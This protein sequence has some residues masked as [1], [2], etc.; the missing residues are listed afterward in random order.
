[1]NCISGGASKNL[2]IQYKEVVLFIEHIMPGSLFASSYDDEWYFG[3]AN[4]ISVEK[5]DMNIKFLQPN[6]PAAQFF[7]PSLEDTCWTPIHNVITKVD[8]PLSMKYAKKVIYL[9]N[10]NE[11]ANKY[12]LLD[13][14]I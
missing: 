3:V 11:I 9:N 14:N 10:K 5:R 6:G 7:R 4:Y 2:L 12:T 13:S 1:M 8:P